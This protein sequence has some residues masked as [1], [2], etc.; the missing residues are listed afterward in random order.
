MILPLEALLDVDNYQRISRHRIESSAI[1]VPV[2]TL[3][4]GFFALQSILL[5]TLRRLSWKRIDKVGLANR[6][7]RGVTSAR[8]PLISS[9]DE[10]LTSLCISGQYSRFLTA[11]LARR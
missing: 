4:P 6:D 5:H 10:K 7:Y 2:E 8:W 9:G 1:L 3:Q 11:P